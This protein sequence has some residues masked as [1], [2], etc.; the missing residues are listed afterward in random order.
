MTHIAGSLMY[1]NFL[2]FQFYDPGSK[3][4]VLARFCFHCSLIAGGERQLDLSV[5]ICYIVSILF[6]S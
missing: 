1:D 2:T 5:L 4:T 3:P 6:C